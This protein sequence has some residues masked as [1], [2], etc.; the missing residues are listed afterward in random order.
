MK[1]KQ[2][3]LPAVILLSAIVWF[4]G[5][6]LKHSLASNSKVSLI[7]WKIDESQIKTSGQLASINFQI[8]SEF[9]VYI[10]RQE[11]FVIYNL[12]DSSGKTF[13]VLYFGRHPEWPPKMHWLDAFYTFSRGDLKGEGVSHFSLRGIS[14]EFWLCRSQF[15]WGIHAKY[16]HLSKRDAAL[17][18]KIIESIQPPEKPNA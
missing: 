8:P 10:D 17:A 12:I 14:K 6:P 3:I 11:D 4:V 16:E 2:T 9:R 15:G 5:K 18:D 1:L 7:D 13:I